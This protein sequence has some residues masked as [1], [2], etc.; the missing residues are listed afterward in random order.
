VAALLAS[1]ENLLVGVYQD[2]IDRR[3]RLG[4]YAPAVTAFL[5]TAQRQHKEHA[6][7]W[8]SILSGAGK[9]GITGVNLNVK[10]AT[11]DP[12]LF[13]ARDAVG[14]LGVCDEVGRVVAT[15]YLAAMG[16][17]QNNAALK[18]AASIH[19]VECEHLGVLAFLLGRQ[20]PSDSFTHVEGARP[21]SDAIG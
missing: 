13:R 20:L 3:E 16:S 19:P 8:N 17:L 15:T 21:T 6:A 10:G 14:L 2:G 18:V 1:L 9:P 5:E 7:A 4:P 11:A 12:A